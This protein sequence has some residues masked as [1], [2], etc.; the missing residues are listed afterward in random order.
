MTFRQVL[1]GIAATYLF[2]SNTVTA[3]VSLGSIT[4][5]MHNVAGE[6]FVLSE[7]V[8]EVRG[9]VYDGE[10][11]A[12]YFWADT[13]AVPSSSGYRLFDGSPFNGCG[14]TPLPEEADGSVTYRVEFPDGGS[15]MDILGGSIS[16]WCEQFAVSFGEVIIPS[17][18]TGI[19]ETASGPDLEC[20]EN[21]EE[22]P[23][24]T[25]MSAPVATPRAAPVPPPT[26][27]TAP[28]APVAAP[29]TAPV[30]APTTATAPTAPVAAPRTAPV[31]APT[32]VTVPAPST[33]TTE[34]P[35]ATADSE[36]FLI[37]NLTTLAHE[38]TG[39]VYLIS[40]HIIEIRVCVYMMLEECYPIHVILIRYHLF[41][42]AN[43]PGIYVRW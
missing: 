10:A 4:T 22:T 26:T 11:P 17:T 33:T 30:P 32:T 25:P 8:L 19:P 35:V 38:V 1:F 43:Y 7:R 37:G 6:V 3:Q 12:V 36:P 20:F 21:V 9:F 40:D 41:A 14:V 28:T 2:G 24:A 39:T 18:L 27:A 29:R 16:L 31:P 34:V 23:V 15:I 42:S 13:N 5:R